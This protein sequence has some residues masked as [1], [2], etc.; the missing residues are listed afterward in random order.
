MT[1]K[2]LMI[3]GKFLGICALVLIVSIWLASVLDQ[4]ELVEWQDPWQQKREHVQAQDYMVVAGTPW[5]AQAAADILD[6]GGNAFDAAVAALLVL[7]VTFGE[8]A[9]FPSIAP[10][11]IYDAKNNESRS[12]VGVGTAPAAA[13]IDAFNARGFK[14]VPKMD[15]YSQLIPA[16]PDVIARL[17][18]QYGTRSFKEVS[19]PAIQIATD[20]FPVHK[21]MLRNL[22]LN[23]FERFAY[24]YLLPYN[25]KVYLDNRWWRPL[26]HKQRFTR[27][28]LAKTLSQLAQAETKALL[29]GG[30]RN[31]GLQAMRDYF[32]NGPLAEKIVKLHKEKS[33]LISADD[34]ANYSGHWEKP[35]SGDF[36]DFEIQTNGTWT[37]GIVVP[38]VLQ[39]LDGIDLKSMGHN[40]EQYVHTVAQAIELV[41]ADRETFIGDPEFNDVPIEQLLSKEYA[42]LRRGLMNKK[43]FN[44]IPNAGAP[45]EMQAN[46]EQVNLNAHVASLYNKT[47]GRDTS[48]LSIVDKDGNAVSMTP[49]DFPHSPM[50]PDTGMTLGIRM[51]QFRLDDTHPSSLEPGKR[52]RVTPHA[53]MVFNKSDQ[54]LYM[55]LGTPGA[56]MQTQALIQVL[57]NHLVFDMDIQTA[58]D[59]PR[60]RSRNLP[61]SFSPHSYSP[62]TLD[63]EDD[64]YQ[65]I[66]VSLNKRGY[67]TKRFEK[68]H[69]HFSAVGAIVLKNNRLFAGADPRE[70]T[71]AIGH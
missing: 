45:L 17:L 30:D 9:S 61:D 55:S 40:S 49:S 13:T 70:G 71:T 39:I 64:L 69:N 12:Y 68:L 6:N 67:T 16:S 62:A 5:A 43:A 65:S 28:D 2:R 27:P 15:I 52:P 32:Y 21:I 66:S 25:A 19:A 14:V 51:T 26:R 3:V 35:L 34:L 46:G 36:Q 31:A 60:F 42:A 1:I 29:N 50:V 10:L 58:V 41:M 7:N 38:M 24:N 44:A 59:Q 23:V 20:G 11:L 63:L 37:Q 56:D 48:Y 4:P 57:L 33:G 54:S 22:D 53:L 18:S 8:A 47:I